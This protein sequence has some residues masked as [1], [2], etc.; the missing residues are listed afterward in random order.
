[1][2]MHRPRFF[3]KALIGMGVAILS[4]VTMP[5]PA[6]AEKIE[7]ICSHSGIDS[8]IGIDTDRQSVDEYI[9]GNH[10]GPFVAS[11]SDA[12]IHWVEVESGTGPNQYIIDRVAGTIRRI[13]VRE[14]RGSYGKC[15]RATQKF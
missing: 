8:H 6:R 10:Y 9:N 4:T 12:F 1:M 15:R 2:A 14:G 3:T 13:V 7:L 11:I 5:T